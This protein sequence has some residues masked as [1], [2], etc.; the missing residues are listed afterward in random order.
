M[1]DKFRVRTW[2]NLRYVCELKGERLYLMYLWIK[3]CYTCIH[4]LVLDVQWYISI[5]VIQQ[6]NLYWQGFSPVKGSH[7][8]DHLFLNFTKTMSK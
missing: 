1:I 8:R 6:G 2:A 5:Y 7:K 4:T 3:T